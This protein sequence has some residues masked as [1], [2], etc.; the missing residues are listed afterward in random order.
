MFVKL[1]IGTADEKKV[2]NAVPTHVN[3]VKILRH[4]IIEKAP[5]KWRETIERDEHKKLCYLTVTEML[6]SY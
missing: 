1:S 5:I 3:L 6:E 2:M 4:E